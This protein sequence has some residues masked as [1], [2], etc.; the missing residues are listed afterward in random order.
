[1]KKVKYEYLYARLLSK[2]E[3]RIDNLFIDKKP[4]SLYEPCKY[5]LESGGK[6][7]RP[8]LLLFSVKAAG[9]NFNEAYNAALAVEIL[10]N[11]TL[12]HDDI[13]DNSPIRRGRPSLYK[14]FDSNTAILAGDNLIA[15]AFKLLLKDC[16]YNTT[17][18]I[19]TFTQGIID[20]CEGQSLDKEFETRKE[21]SL[22]EYRFMIQKKTA[23]LLS[24][25]TSIGG[26][27]AKADDSAMRIL[28][29]YGKNLG[30]AFQI[31]DDLLD[32]I[33]DEKKFGKKVGSDLIE[34][35]KTFL[36]LKALEKARGGDKKKLLNVIKNCGIESSE[37]ESY[38]QIYEKYGVLD[39]AKTEINK[40]I[41]LALK[42]LNG[43]PDKEGSEMLYLLA[44]S[45]INRTK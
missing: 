37:I 6:R 17:Q 14:K 33:A 22:M 10:H 23:A 2:I 36:F 40:Y 9:G 15:I 13:M 44:N 41:K 27:I 43:L 31:Q 30:M 45:L 26:L 21:V 42:G 25:C 3:K 12:V 35:K 39:D 5:A 18:I 20:V 8:I 34:G 29:N 4:L 16:K 19:E 28:K 32:I 11:F 1:M 38:T 24:A 7:L